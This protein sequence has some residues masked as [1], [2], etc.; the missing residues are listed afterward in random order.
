[1]ERQ[2]TQQRNGTAAPAIPA[3][4]HSY[5]M[6]QQPG[7]TTT[8]QHNNLA[9]GGPQQHSNTTI[10]ATDSRTAE[11]PDSQTGNQNVEHRTARGSRQPDNR[12]ARQQEQQAART[13]RTAE[14]NQKQTTG[15]RN[16]GA[17]GNRTTEQTMLLTPQH[18]K[19]Y[20]QIN[21]SQS[22]SGL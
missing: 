1:V 9:T 10:P 14:R 22:R 2:A 11:Q 6:A 21:Y 13:A 17:A 3:Q 19:K 20:N 4:W 12:T 8:Q 5:T 18:P 16:N 7:N 15:N